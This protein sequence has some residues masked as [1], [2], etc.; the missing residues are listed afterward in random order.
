MR[1]LLVMN[2]MDPDLVNGIDS[3]YSQENDD[4]GMSVQE[5]H[6]RYMAELSNGREGNLHLEDGYVCTVC[7]NKG[8]IIKAECSEF[9]YWQQVQY[10]CQCMTMR[11][12]IR[13]MKRSGLEPS[14]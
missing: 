1:K 4:D 13:Q 14:I 9:G 12:A 7:K 10:D 11:R 3:V 8:Y 2:G 6:C 5:R